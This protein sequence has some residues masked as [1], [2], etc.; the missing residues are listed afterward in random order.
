MLKRSVD[1]GLL[2]SGSVR[3]IV[4]HGLSTIDLRCFRKGCFE[5]DLQKIINRL[6]KFYR[7]IGKII[8]FNSILYHI[9]INCISHTGRTNRCSPPPRLRRKCH[10]SAAV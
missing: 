8:K 3:Q 1:R 9:L 2:I 5:E 10:I 6:K 7:I 4:E